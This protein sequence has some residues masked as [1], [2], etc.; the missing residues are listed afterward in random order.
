[1]SFQRDTETLGNENPIGLIPGPELVRRRLLQTALMLV[2]AVITDAGYASPTLGTPARLP[3]FDRAR[4]IILDVV[5]ETIIP[6]TDTP[7]AR[8][9]GVPARFDA[10]MSDWASQE[11]R[12]SFRKALD[13][14]DMSAR[15]SYARGIAALTDKQKLTIVEAYDNERKSDRTY[16]R[17]KYLIFSLYYMSEPGATQE[18]RY[19]HVPGVWEPNTKITP[20]TRAWAWEFQLGGS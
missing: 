16:M 6:R 20:E 15:T 1:M 9:V 4:Y 19:E 18:L 10:M 11:T 17:L 3:F 7:G 13:E 8:D 12:N 14:I 2:G 5:A